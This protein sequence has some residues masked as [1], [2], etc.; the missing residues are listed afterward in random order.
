MCRKYMQAWSVLLAFAPLILWVATSCQK[1][2]AST[3]DED[4]G[5]DAGEP[6]I[7]TDFTIELVDGGW[8]GARGLSLACTPDGGTAIAEERG[9]YLYLLEMMSG[10]EISKTL[11]DKL[12]RWPALAVDKSGHY[13]L[14]YWNGSL[15]G[16]M[17]ATNAAG[18]WTTEKIHETTDPIVR[19]RIAVDGT[20]AVHIAFYDGSVYTGGS[21]SEA[22]YA[23]K[24]AEQWVIESVPIAVDNII[25]LACDRVGVC[26]ILYDDMEA[27][28]LRIASRRN[29]MWEMET[30]DE[31]LEWFDYPR[32]SMAT[33]SSGKVHVAYR[34]AEGIMYAAEQDD[35]YIV[36]PIDTTLY[37]EGLV[38]SVDSSDRPHIVYFD[39]LTEELH[40]LMLDS[41]G[42]AS[43]TAPA[44]LIDSLTMDIDAED[45]VRVAFKGM[46]GEVTDQNGGLVYAEEK[47]GWQSQLVDKGYSEGRYAALAVTA[48]GSAHIAYQQALVYRARFSSN[49][50]G[51]WMSETADAVT[52][53]GLFTSV[54]SDGGG[55]P[56]MV[57]IV[58]KQN[59]SE[60]QR[61]RYRHR[62]EDGEWAQEDIVDEG[63]YT[64]LMEP[65]VVVDSVGR[66][67][68]VYH[69]DWVSQDETQGRSIVRY[70]RRED[71]G[72]WHQEAVFEIE[73]TAGESVAGYE[74]A[75]VLDCDDTPHVAF[76]Y[77][78]KSEILYAVRGV[79]GNWDVNTAVTGLGDRCR[80]VSLAVDETKNAYITFLHE[81]EK[82]AGRVTLELATR[83]SASG[84]W[85]R[86]TLDTFT[87]LRNK[88]KTSIS[89]D[90]D[91]FLHISYVFKDEGDPR[92]RYA[93]NKS[94]E[95]RKTDIDTTGWLGDY[96]ALKID[97]YGL[98]H[99]AY[100]AE[101]A[102]WHARFPAGETDLVL[103]P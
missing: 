86:Q 43:A 50:G 35:S 65:S 37:S 8:P 80:G 24:T 49:E 40:H 6:E 48:N 93:T 54:A 79:E 90:T 95:W 89:S 18:E 20:G 57:Y 91:G 13:H 63:G 83:P 101:D 23:T 78:S 102:L 22:F 87:E 67:Q 55:Q 2:T 56:L 85:E 70:A 99:I 9:R 64:H 12:I 28:A 25:E 77:D 81:E 11:V 27:E 17:Y 88:A 82:Y 47:T 33:D 58:D 66:V 59:D 14:T 84:E 94:G 38:L 69:E 31:D 30:I 53:S 92:L 75:L 72:T 41:D 16:V 103:V 97:P 21:T 51:A 15:N 36:D 62:S 100:D 7:S 39:K 5:N 68:V 3:S 32:F 1:G 44:G 19:S 73:G 76:R 46:V 71:N 74:P 61:L 42:W 10:E 52:E 34:N 29:D 45:S 4:S 60:P 96:N 26:H 98:I